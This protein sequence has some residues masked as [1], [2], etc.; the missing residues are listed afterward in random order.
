[1]TNITALSMEE[2]SSV[3]GGCDTLYSCAVEAGKWVA[4]RIEDG[5]DA[6]AEAYQ[7]SQ[8]NFDAAAAA[9]NHID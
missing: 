4:N 5:V 8:E 6:V 1:M 3:N 2:V 7:N 9:G